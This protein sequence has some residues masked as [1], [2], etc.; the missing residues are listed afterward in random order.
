MLTSRMMGALFAVASRSS[1][2]VE[3][4]ASGDH[5]VLAHAVHRLVDDARLRLVGAVDQ[6]RDL[7]ARRE[8]RLHLRCPA[9]RRGRPSDG[10]RAG[11]AVA[12][13]TRPVGLADPRTARNCGRIRPAPDATNSSGTCSSARAGL[14]S[15]SSAWASERRT[16][17]SR[18]VALVDDDAS[19]NS[20]PGLLFETEDLLEPLVVEQVVFPD[21]FANEFSHRVALRLARDSAPVPV[22]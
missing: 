8:H 2:V 1:D 12:T 17:F 10:C 4:G 15:R 20:E 9:W 6:R 11:Y 7:G 5:V 21:E 18:H 22:R 16:S 14:Y 13:R 3:R 19:R